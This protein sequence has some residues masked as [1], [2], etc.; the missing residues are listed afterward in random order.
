M[1]NFF[2]QKNNFKKGFTLVE[3]LVALSIFTTAVLAMLIILSQGISQTS[4]AKNKLVATYLAQEGV[5]YFRNLRDN[6]MLYG[7]NGFIDFNKALNDKK[8]L[9]TEGCGFI[10]LSTPF[11]LDT[12]VFYCGDVTSTD[13]QLGLYEGKYSP[14]ILNP[15]PDSGFKRVVTFTSDDPNVVHVVSTVYW[16]QNSGEHSVSFSE[17]LLGWY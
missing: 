17:D 12:D 9:N 8:C 4:Y 2:I 13:C 14:I 5:E 3:T 7:A 11:Q 1:K 15:N 10:D 6:Y 16:V